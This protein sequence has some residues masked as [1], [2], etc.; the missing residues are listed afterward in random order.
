[1]TLLT[2]LEYRD[3]IKD[4]LDLQDE[5]FID[6]TM[7]MA[8][9]NNAIDE[10]EQHILGRHEDYFLQNSNIALVAGTSEYSL[11]SNILAHKIRRVF[12]DD[13]SNKYELK[14]IRNLS[15]IPLI[16]TG[17]NYRY[18]LI[19]NST[20]GHRLKL[21]PTSAETSSTNISVWYIGNA[22]RIT[23]TSDT[24]NIPEAINF[25]LAAVKLECLRREGN[26]MQASMEAEKERQKML[27][28]DTLT[29]IV[30]DDDNEIIPDLSFYN[31]FDINQG[32]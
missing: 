18:V 15:E 2:W 23:A 29:E 21:Y 6:N 30:P 10:A 12:Y 8:W 3:Q 1:M 20:G 13:G 17:E 14:R 19:A 24:V 11:P 16:E 26:P 4:D 9:M 5:T 32:C 7:L 28:V 22:T 27:L 31:E 25:L